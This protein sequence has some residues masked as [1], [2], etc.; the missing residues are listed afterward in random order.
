MLEN[1]WN[2]TDRYRPIVLCESSVR[3]GADTEHRRIV[4]AIR[5]R[6][7]DEAERLMREHVAGTRRMI[8]GVAAD[9]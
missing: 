1:L 6:N 4:S 2:R 5:G 7:E 3:C 8:E 9:Q